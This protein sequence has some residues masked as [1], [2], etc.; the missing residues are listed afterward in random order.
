MVKREKKCEKE[1]EK[2]E[3]AE[4]DQKSKCEKTKPEIDSCFVFTDT[5]NKLTSGTLVARFKPST[6]DDFGLGVKMFVRFLLWMGVTFVAVGVLYFPTMKIYSD[7]P[8]SD[9]AFVSTF[10]SEL[11]LKNV[12]HLA[13]K[14]SKRGRAFDTSSKHR[15][16]FAGA[17]LS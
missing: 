5:E 14:Q 7:T 2:C 6:Y 9:P 13:A 3:N 8:A 4:K 16:P 1:C 12:A 10:T 17:G 15:V 11:S